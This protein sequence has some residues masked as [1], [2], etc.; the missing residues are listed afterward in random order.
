MATP[1]QAM[2]C[3]IASSAADSPSTAKLATPKPSGVRNA[4]IVVTSIGTSSRLVSTNAG[5]PSRYEP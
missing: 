2:V 1:I 4:L 5:S 3:A